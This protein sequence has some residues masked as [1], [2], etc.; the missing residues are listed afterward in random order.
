MP[1]SFNAAR[2]GQ[3]AVQKWVSGRVYGV[4]HI[5]WSP[6]NQLLYVRLVAG[7]GTTD[8]SADGT[9]WALFG[10]TKPK[11]MRRGVIVIAGGSQTSNTATLSPAVDVTKTRLRKGGHYTTGGDTLARDTDAQ[12]V[13]TNSTTITATRGNAGAGDVYVSWELE[14]LW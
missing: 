4:D 8:P 6:A 13:L 1:A 5:V 10:P 9:N 3:A 7:G 2:G 14:E 11:P 12:L